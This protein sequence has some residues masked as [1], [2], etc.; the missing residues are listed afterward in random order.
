M[1]DDAKSIKNENILSGYI[2]FFYN[3]QVVERFLESR[4]LTLTKSVNIKHKIIIIIDK[5]GLDKMK[6]M[7]VFFDGASNF[8]KKKEAFRHY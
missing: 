7:S 4:K 8:S 2:R 6:M 1:C 5:F 3:N